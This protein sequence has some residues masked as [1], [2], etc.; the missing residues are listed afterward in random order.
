MLRLL[1][2]LLLLC[3]CSN[4]LTEE[5]IRQQEYGDLYFTMNCWWG[6][7][8]TFGP[9]IVACSEE[10]STELISGFVSFAMEKDLENREF[11]SICGRNIELNTGYTLHDNLIPPLTE[12]YNCFDSYEN[13]LGNGFDWLWDERE[14]ILQIIWRPGNDPDKVLTLFVDPPGD[15]IQVSGRVY[16]KTGYFN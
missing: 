5:D 16:Y 15:N 7:Q 11:L 8:S 13:E 6:S 12:Y 1:I 2:L 10:V 9:I 3:S 4:T 14:R